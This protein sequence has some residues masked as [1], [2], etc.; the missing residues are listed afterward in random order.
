MRWFV[1]LHIAPFTRGAQLAQIPFG[2]LLEEVGWC[3]GNAWR[4]VNF[5]GA[6]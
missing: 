3:R 5:N 1:T 2:T 6:K 4:Q